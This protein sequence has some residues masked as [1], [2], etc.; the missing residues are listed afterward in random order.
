MPTHQTVGKL[1]EVRLRILGIKKPPM[2][3]GE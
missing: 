1:I 3:G 2:N